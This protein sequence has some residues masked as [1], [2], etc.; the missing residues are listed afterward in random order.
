MTATGEADAELVVHI[1]TAGNFGGGV[2]GAEGRGETEPTT[3]TRIGEGV[4][5]RGRRLQPAVRRSVGSM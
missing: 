2:L 3:R 4:T 1:A 5:A